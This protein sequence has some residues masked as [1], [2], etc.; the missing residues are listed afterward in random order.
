MDDKKE[1]KKSEVKAD[2][3]RKVGRTIVALGTQG[4]HWYLSLSKPNREKAVAQL[5]AIERDA[6]NCM[7]RKELDAHY[8]S[9]LTLNPDKLVDYVAE[10]RNNVKKPMNHG[11][12][13]NLLIHVTMIHLIRGTMTKEAIQ[14]LT[15]IQSP[16]PDELIGM[17]KK[18][19]T[20]LIKHHQNIGTDST[21]I[22]DFRNVRSGRVRVPPPMHPER[23]DED[24]HPGEPPQGMRHKRRRACS[25]GRRRGRHRG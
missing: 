1:K 4:C 25:K 18:R 14:H 24:E 15:D 9:I 16:T 17:S 6:R 23:D 8:E 5:A 7:T 2:L 12:A 11:A 21:I 20:D 13:S 10:L 22:K 3:E 19:F